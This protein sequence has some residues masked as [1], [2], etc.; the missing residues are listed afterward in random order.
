[1]TMTACGYQQIASTGLATAVGLTIPTTSQQKPTQC[2]ITCET[3]A[4]RWRDD[5]VNPTATVGYPLAVG[6]ELR[7]DGNLPAIRFIEQTAS[8]VLNVSYYYG[9]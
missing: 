3:Q 8:A 6:A 2:I 9:N 5:G 4:I 7:Y 1:M